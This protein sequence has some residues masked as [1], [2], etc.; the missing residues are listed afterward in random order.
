MH[1]RSI[2]ATLKRAA[3]VGPLAHGMTIAA[4]ISLF[5]MMVMMT[6]HVFSRKI[7]L[8]LPGAFEASEQLMVVVFAF[9]LAE[10][11]LKRGHI[12]FELIS[13]KFP[14]A[15]KKRMELVGAVVGLLVFAPLTYKAWEI[16]FEM[17]AIGE[18]RQGIIN[19]PIWPFRMMIALGLTLFAYQ[20]VLSCIRPEAQT[21]SKGSP[22]ES[23]IG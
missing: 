12:V 8:P 16:A 9:P 20:L 15:L 2:A 18:Y 14:S 4:G 5:A 23:Q 17:Y 3:N 22:E 10:I 6:I 7:G 11:S 21:R 19:F 1:S 13:E